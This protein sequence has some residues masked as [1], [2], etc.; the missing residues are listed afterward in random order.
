VAFVEAGI[1]V[2]EVAAWPRCICGPGG[3]EPQCVCGSCAAGREVVGQVAV[4]S[5]DRVREVDNTE[6]R[7]VVD[8]RNVIRGGVC[9]WYCGSLRVSAEG[10][11]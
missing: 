8:V 2:L 7:Q 3:D 6:L 4:V 5:V 10:Y 9:I 1:K 11:D